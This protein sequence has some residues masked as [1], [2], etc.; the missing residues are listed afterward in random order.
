M[1]HC[2]STVVYLLARNVKVKPEVK[3]IE[4]ESGIFIF[5]PFTPMHWGVSLSLKGTELTLTA[6]LGLKITIS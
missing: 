2:T 6:R 4:T 1:S 5:I 3:S